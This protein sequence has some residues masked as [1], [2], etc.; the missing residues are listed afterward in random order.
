MKTFTTT[1]TVLDSNITVPTADRQR[2]GKLFILAAVV[3][4]F[5]VKAGD[6]LASEATTATENGIEKTSP[7][8][9]EEA[10]VIAGVGDSP[11]PATEHLQAEMRCLALNIYFE[12]RS[13]PES[14]QRAVAHVVMNRLAHPKYPDSVCAVVKQGG[15]AVRHRCQFSWWCDGHSD[16]PSNRKAWDKA[17]KLARK[18]FAGDLE[19]TT[20][21]ALWY[22][23][24]YVKPYWSELLLKGERIGQHVFYLENRAPSETL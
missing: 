23:A 11:E 4:S 17:L 10:Q 12:A 15:E 18:V 8:G 13:E 21:G 24:T 9:G 22:H 16:Q 20:G 19:D 1:N 3:M 14:G 6:V 7:L 2:P 5:L